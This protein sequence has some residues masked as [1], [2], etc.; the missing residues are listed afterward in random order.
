M[1][2]YVLG[3]DAGTESIRSGI[4]NEKGECIS[5]GV[6]ENTNIHRHPGWGEQNVDKW[7]SQCWSLS[8][9]HSKTVGTT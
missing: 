5:F 2:R 9:S 1:E 4:Y 6:S 8:S 7:S 3:I